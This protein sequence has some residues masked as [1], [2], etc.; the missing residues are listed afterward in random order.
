M[1]INT[2]PVCRLEFGEWAIYHEHLSLAHGVAHRHEPA[3][4]RIG[5]GDM[6]TLLVTMPK[7]LKY[8][9]YKPMDP[10]EKRRVVAAL[11]GRVSAL[12]R[13]KVMPEA[14]IR[15]YDGKHVSAMAYDAYDATNGRNFAVGVKVMLK[16][17]KSYEEKRIDELQGLVA[18]LQNKNRQG[19]N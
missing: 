12:E 5:L 9:T 19:G 15:F 11:D 8:R 7:D 14:D 2:C 16:L 6:A 13:L 1:K 18:S 4:I 17:G 10:I 3:P